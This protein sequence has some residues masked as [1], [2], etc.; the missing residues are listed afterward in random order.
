MGYQKVTTYLSSLFPQK[1]LWLFLLAG[2]G[3]ILSL[4]RRNRIGLYLGVM[5]VLA[6][7]VFRYAPQARLWN[8]RVL[9]F[10][11]LC[12]FLLVG[13]AFL[14]AGTMMVDALRQQEIRNVLLIPVPVVTLLV[15]LIWVNFPLH[16]LPFGHVT[17]SGKYDWLGISSDDSSFIPSWVSWN[18][19]GYQ[20]PGKAREQEYFALVDKMKQLGQNPA[21][22]CGRA[23]WEYEPEFDQM[24]TPDALMLLPY[25][26]KGCIGSEEGLYYE[27]SATTPYHFLNAAEL[28]DQPSNPVRGL[29]Y[30]SGPNVEEGIQHLQML[31][32]KYFMAITPDVEAA[33]D[34]DNQ[35][36][37]VATVGPYPVTYTTGSKSSV[38]Q[39]TW[40]IYE[41]A[42]S[43]LVTP[44]EYQP[45]VM[46]GVSQGGQPW[47]TA[48]ESWYLDPNRW[49][50][51]EAAS[52]PKSWARVSSTATKLPRTPLP[53]VQVTNIH[54]GNESISF[55]VDQTGVPV[56]VKTSYFPNWQASG[57]GTVYRVTP[58]LMVVIPTS[59][60][61]TLNYGY[62]P[63]DWI[64]F[65]LS[66]LAVAGV[67]VV[68]RRR[69]P[70]F[71]PS[72]H[73][74]FVD[75]SGTGGPGGSTSPAASADEEAGA[76]GLGG[77]DGYA[78]AAAEGAAISAGMAGSPGDW[79][80][81]GGFPP[82]AKVRSRMAAFDPDALAA[83]FK[84]Y[85]IRGIVPDQLNTDV[86]RAVGS[87]FARF[88]GDRLSGGRAGHAAV[89]LRVDARL[90]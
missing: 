18:Y 29:N 87:A 15:A 67:L 58:N 75:A 12:L 37:L 81:P 70:E 84:A 66:L 51:Y 83:V 2:A 41:V 16:N 78:G 90:R 48:S 17:A 71:G 5:T 72:R 57:A 8:A 74:A 32:V 19:S 25:W 21:Y 27:S 49:N 88:A 6:A 20:S 46:K 64:G 39:R 24:G 73:F 4:V 35:L 62:T 43:A 1:D 79:A 26:T 9:P 77:P 38:E 59:H 47:L 42:D 69:P 80:P 50:V 85:D 56:L 28:S 61:V 13:I 23:M 10:W 82:A 60:H 7:L 14:E 22:G 33:A 40:K 30:P 76:G 31:G 45:V 3:L 44:L 63:V 68:W 89:G 65:I 55:D 11:Y 36:Q 54:Q 34:A 52:G 86:A 53:P